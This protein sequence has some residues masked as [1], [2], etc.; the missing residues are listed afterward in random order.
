MTRPAAEAQGL[1]LLAATFAV[2]VAG[3][4][5]E[6]IAGAVSS[7]LL[8][9]SVTQFSLVIGVFMTSMG[10][11]AWASRYVTE[12][13]RG[14]VLSQVLLGIVGGFSAPIL[15]L[16]YGWLDGLGLLLFS[17]VVAIGALSG[18]E[19]PLITRILHTRQAMQHTLS[20]VLT[21]DYAGALVAAVLFPL[22]IVPQLGLMA[23]SLV[24]GVLN[25]VVAGISLWLFRERIG[26]LIRGFWLGGLVACSAALIWT[27][28]LVSLADTAMFED[29]VILSEETPYQRIVVTRFGDRTR[30]FL[31]GSIQFDSLDE[32]RYHETLV[33][34]MMSRLPRRTS[35]LILGGGD[36]M[37]AREV[38]RWPD[39]EE[40][41]L[42]DLDPRVTELFRNVPHLAALNDRALN[43]P[44]VEIIADDA[45][46]FAD[47][48]RRVFDAIVLD[49]P[50]PRDFSVS[51]L[52]SRE[53]Y[54]RL[55]ERL[56]PRGALVTQAGSPVFAREAFWSIDRT[57]DETRDPQRPGGTL[58][59][60]AY[61]AYVPSFGTWG[62]V[63]ARPGPLRDPDPLPEG[64]QFYHADLWPGLTT[65]GHD[66]APLEVET[67]TILSHALVRYY[68]DG[69][70]RW[71]R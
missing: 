30:L 48:D 5:Y 70:A 32:H 63:L 66:T 6:L 59:T 21:A 67:N 31:N 16:A 10:L 57:L 27:D 15:F 45:W 43:D 56:S 64:L 4:V 24:F 33:H 55:V 36:G 42:V 13:E 62:F 52:Y 23:A 18:L 11:G 54:A 2:A 60:T 69:W 51:K 44:R 50:D 37:A 58:S 28:R 61:H 9:D 41:V 49:L 68:E 7:Y 17:L 53:F 34:P 19:I 3:L 8:G 1:W 65:F 29:D 25:L 35:I 39:V 47:E 40:V 71:F 22:V 20:S 26:W 38:L 46:Q 12:A 14:F